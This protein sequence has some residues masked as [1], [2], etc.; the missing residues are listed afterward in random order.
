MGGQVLD[1]RMKEVMNPTPSF[2]G[3]EVLAWEAMKRMEVDYQRR[4]MMLPD[5]SRPRCQF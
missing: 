3:P 4:I 1:V 5:A 2:V